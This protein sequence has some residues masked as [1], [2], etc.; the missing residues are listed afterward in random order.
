ME[1]CLDAMK[2]ILARED[3]HGSL[4]ENNL[5]S[6]AEQNKITVLEY[7]DNKLLYWSNNE[8]DVPQFLNDSI[9]SRN[10]VFLQNGWFLPKTI[11]AGNEI[12]VGLLRLRTEYS[13]ENDIIKSGFEKDF[14]IPESV[15][16]STDKA[17]SDYHVSNRNGEFLFSL[18]FPEVKVKTTFI[19]MPLLLWALSFILILLLTLELAK[20]LVSKGWNLQAVFFVLLMFSSLYTLILATGKPLVLFQTELFSPYRF[21]YNNNVPSL[22]HLLLLSIL[23]ASFSNVFFRHFPVKIKNHNRPVR[24]FSVATLLLIPGAL[25]T[26]IYHLVF[27]EMISTSNINFEAYKVLEINLFSIVGFTAAILLVIVPVLYLL[28][29]FQSL[30]Q[31]RPGIIF[32][33]ILASLFVIAAVFRKDSTTLIPL[34]LFYLVL[35]IVLWRSGYSGVGFFNMAVIFSLIFGVYS[36]YF[37]TILSEEKTTENLKIKAV[38]LSTENDPDAEH[39]FLDMWPDISTDTLLKS[40]MHTDYFDKDDVDKISRYLQENYFGGYL[41][42]FNF[43]IVLCRNDE[44]LNVG[45]GMK[46]LKTASDFLMNA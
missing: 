33:S 42:N 22:G 36:L 5:F 7:L 8:F 41:S 30:R 40:M 20:L 13:F 4:N 6:T 23:A 34:S 15:G 25:L 27:R 39:M 44:S 14:K 1:E 37:I 3:H 18:I 17:D 35:A 32:I 43:K 11:R 16:F 31:F 29:I 10:I 21:S 46:S 9:F 28:K 45:P 24:D 2:P 12:I 38:S 26:A 19:F